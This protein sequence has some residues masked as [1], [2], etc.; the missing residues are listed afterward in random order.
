MGLCVRMFL[1]GNLMPVSSMVICFPQYILYWLTL[2]GY[3]S[4][5]N[6]RVS[7][8]RLCLIG[9]FPVE[10]DG[11]NIEFLNCNGKL[12]F[13]SN[14]SVVVVRN[15][16][17]F[18]QYE[19]YNDII[20]IISSSII[21]I[22][23][24]ILPVL[25]SDST[26]AVTKL[27]KLLISQ[28]VKQMEVWFVT[29]DN[30]VHVNLQMLSSDLLTI[31]LGKYRCNL[32]FNK[33]KYNCLSAMLLYGTK[34]LHL[35]KVLFNAGIVGYMKGMWCDLKYV[36]NYLNCNRREYSYRRYLRI[37]KCFGFLNLNNSL[38]L[39]NNFNII[40]MDARIVVNICLSDITALIV[41]SVFVSMPLMKLSYG[42]LSIYKY[43]NHYS[44]VSVDLKLIN[45]V[46][47]SSIGR[48]IINVITKQSHCNLEVLTK[49]DLIHL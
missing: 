5:L 12:L 29:G 17:N 35:A 25:N 28:L 34:F 15:E 26:I 31:E 33:I 32:I 39:C 47:I 3:D 38:V 43:I 37:K 48:G 44:V 11:F 46:D 21:K 9:L 7:K 49:Y 20:Y 6:V 8:L 2:F 10:V 1:D 36:N 23:L 4:D 19:I 14:A 24:L 30:G 45:L 42:V 22:P 41:S 16:F 13:D 40:P 18:I 27:N